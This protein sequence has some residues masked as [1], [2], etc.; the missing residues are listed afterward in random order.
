VRQP[1]KVTT[2]PLGLT[3]PASVVDMTRDGAVYKSSGQLAQSSSCV[4]TFG[5][6]V[7]GGREYRR[8]RSVC[9]SRP[10]GRPVHRSATVALH[11]QRRRGDHP[12]A[13]RRGRRDANLS[14]PGS[15]FSGR[16]EEVAVHNPDGSTR[17]RTF[18]HRLAQ[19]TSPSGR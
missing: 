1:V 19:R 17:D 15:S 14:P 12:D 18:S 11:W 16:R 6:R 5:D 10:S 7:D 2:T 3:S 9:G 8:R 13:D 4:S